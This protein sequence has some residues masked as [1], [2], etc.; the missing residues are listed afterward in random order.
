MKNQISV[1]ICLNLDKALQITEIFSDFGDN[2]L[3]N[4]RHLLKNVHSVCRPDAIV[5]IQKDNKMDKD[6]FFIAPL[7]KTNDIL[8]KESNWN[9]ILNYSEKLDNDEIIYHNKYLCN[10][11]ECDENSFVVIT[12]VYL[13]EKYYGCL[14]ALYLKDSLGFKLFSDMDLHYYRLCANIIASQEKSY[15]MKQKIKKINIFRKNLNELST[16]LHQLHCKDML[17]YI[18]KCLEI[19]CNLW[20]IDRGY[21][22]IID[23]DNKRMYKTNEYCSENV[24]SLIEEENIVKLTEFPWNHI[25]LRFKQKIAPIHINN[26]NEEIQKL[27]DK[28]AN[29]NDKEIYESMKKEVEYLKNVKKLKSIL[30]IPI[31][32]NV[33]DVN[34]TIGVL[35]FSQVFE[36]IY[37]KQEL[38]ETLDVLSC[39]ISEAIKRYNSYMTANENEKIFITKINEW[40]KE[41][42]ANNKTFK[43]LKDKMDTILLHHSLTNEISNILV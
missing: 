23:Y 29:A 9:K 41:N 14:V 32:D 25:L 22:F 1:P 27:M 7:E 37:F 4:I 6:L 21:L 5:Y 39:Y 33:K 43:L 42:E 40:E 30:L 3:Y 13:K 2:E 15:K 31:T 38:I 24:D 19:T 8:N 36:Y 12:N 18:D 35:G 16:M 20:G 34:Y 10:I 17:T 28:A 26:I 11:F